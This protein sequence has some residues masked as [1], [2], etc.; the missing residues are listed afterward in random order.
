MKRFFYISLLLALGIAGQSKAVVISW[1]S[2]ALASG[3][4][5]ASLIYVAEGVP[6]Y[7]DDVLQNGTVIGTASG[8]A[9]DGTTLYAQTSDDVTRAI[10]NYYVVLFNDSS[11]YAVSTTVLPY[12]DNTAITRDLMYPASGTFS[13]DTFSGWAPVPEPG[14][15]MLLLLGGVVVALR[16]RKMA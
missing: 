14:T 9:I 2:E 15:A 4:T 16:R 10:G 8:Y 5:S 7:A 3:T 12:D 1:A 11:E 6:T 13:P